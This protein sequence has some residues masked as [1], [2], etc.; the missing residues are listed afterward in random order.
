MK[1]ITFTSVISKVTSL[2]TSAHLA[3]CVRYLCHEEALC[4]Y[5]NL[6]MEKGKKHMQMREDIQFSQ[7]H[8]PPTSSKPPIW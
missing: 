5:T 6:E 8:E 1:N 2:V 4:Y 7:K 3:F